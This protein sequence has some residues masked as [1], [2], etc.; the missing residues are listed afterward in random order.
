MSLHQSF[1]LWKKD[2]HG[3]YHPRVLTVCDGDC[4]QQ[5]R[6]KLKDADFKNDGDDVLQDQG[7]RY[8]SSSFNP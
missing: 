2:A 3:I 7:S 4:P 8:A 5:Q 1:K 6:M